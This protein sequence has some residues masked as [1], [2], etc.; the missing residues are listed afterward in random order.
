[1][2]DEKQ[3]WVV[4]D[5]ETTGFSPR[6]GA[7]LL[8]IAA[9]RVEGNRVCPEV[10]Q[11]FVDPGVSIPRQIT[12]LT[13]LTDAMVAGSPPVQEAI[14][15]FSLFIQD[16]LLVFQNAPFDLA[17]LDD[18]CRC[19][20]MEVFVN[21]YV[22]TIHLSRALFHGKHNL[23]AILQ[24]LRIS[25]PPDQR[26]RALGD[27]RATAQAFVRMVEKVGQQNLHRFLRFRTLSRESG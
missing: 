25:I 16:A 2:I 27:A 5:T 26:H 12:R 3:P 23:D 24:R 21:P 9:V 11:T 1:M 14:G 6:A 13:G 8:E 7:K 10:F 4:V 17:F 20:G 18:A 22:D 15:Q 19:S